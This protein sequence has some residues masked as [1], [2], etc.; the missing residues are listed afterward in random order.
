LDLQKDNNSLTSNLPDPFCWFQPPFALIGF[1]L[2]C[3]Q[4]TNTTTNSYVVF[5]ATKCQDFASCIPRHD[6]NAM[7]VIKF[8]FAT[9]FHLVRDSLCQSI[10]WK[11]LCFFLFSGFYFF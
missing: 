2:R 7:D 6:L 5:R 10:V 8:C 1:C 11:S 4:G 9:P 3:I